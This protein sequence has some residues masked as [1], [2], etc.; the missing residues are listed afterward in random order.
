M[1]VFL[2]GIFGHP[3]EFFNHMETTIAGEGL[4]FLTCA[5]HSWSLSSKACKGSLASTYIFHIYYSSIMLFKWGRICHL[6]RHFS[7]AF[8]RCYMINVLVTAGEKT[9]FITSNDLCNFLVT[10]LVL[11]KIEFLILQ[12]IIIFWKFS[13]VYKMKRLNFRHDECSRY[14][15]DRHIAYIH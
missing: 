14:S 5:R 12:D 4:P 9:I 15:S 10:Q 6:I 1:F 11:C 2:F 8:S 13:D 3:W 7:W